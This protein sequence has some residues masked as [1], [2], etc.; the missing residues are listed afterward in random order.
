MCVAKM[1]SLSDSRREVS[2]KRSIILSQTVKKNKQVSSVFGSCLIK[3]LGPDLSGRNC[4][5]HT[6]QAL[7]FKLINGDCVKNTGV[8]NK[9]IGYLRSKGLYLG[10]I[11]Y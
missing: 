7:I 5:W 8:K 2:E 10:S 3:N 1:W 6:T 11:T 9:C 4:P